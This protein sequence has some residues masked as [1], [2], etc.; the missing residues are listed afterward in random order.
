MSCA[1]AELAAEW[2]MLDD[3]VAALWMTEDGPSPLL[4]DERR[5]TI[6]A[7]AVKLTPQSVAGAMFIAWLVGLHASIA[8]D[9][10][11]GQDERSRHLEAAVTG[12]RSLARYL[13]GRLP[14]PEAS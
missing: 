7:Q 3:H 13:A 6:E 1:V 12:S 8:N 4:L 14:L 9:E 10:D 5:L 2:A 11:A